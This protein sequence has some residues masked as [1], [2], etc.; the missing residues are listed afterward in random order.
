MSPN[1]HIIFFICACADGNSDISRTAGPIRARW[2]S[3]ESW[4]SAL[5]LETHAHALRRYRSYFPNGS[6]DLPLIGGRALG[7][8]YWRL[9]FGGGALRNFRC[10]GMVLISNIHAAR[11]LREVIHQILSRFLYAP[12]L[13]TSRR[14]C[15]PSLTPVAHNPTVFFF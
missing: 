9:I 3:L 7:Q 2:G 6:S 13:T 12:E 5:P 8:T 4:G 11:R 1:P 15:F 14:R 10:P